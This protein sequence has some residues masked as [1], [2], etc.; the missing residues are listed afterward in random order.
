MPRY[1]AFFFIR[2]L[3]SPMPM[4][5][6][7]ARHARLM[8]PIFR[9][10]CRHTAAATVAFIY[11]TP[12][13]MPFGYAITLYFAYFRQMLYAACSMLYAMLIFFFF[14]FSL[15]RFATLSCRYARMADYCLITP[16][17]ITT[18]AARCL[19]LRCASF[20]DISPCRRR[21]SSS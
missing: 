17:P 9:R 14:A 16:M 8:P 20:I 2:F 1:A 13:A 6:L 18:D 21:V 3:S 4:F 5:P 7:S 19:L 15:P 11:V 12:D 10:Y